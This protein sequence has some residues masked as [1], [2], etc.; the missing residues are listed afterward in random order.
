M[1]IIPKALIVIYFVGMI[2]SYI[3]IRGRIKNGE[4]LEGWR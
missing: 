3:Y 1:Y 4:G 2:W